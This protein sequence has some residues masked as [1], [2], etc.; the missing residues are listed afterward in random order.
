MNKFSGKLGYSTTSETKPGVFTE[1][2]VE[3]DIVGDII[4]NASR[5]ENNSK[6]NLDIAENTQVSIVRSPE[7]PQN[8]RLIKYVKYWGIA[9]AIQKVKYRYPRLLITLGGEY[10]V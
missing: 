10:N 3:L 2:I 1:T 4:E 8:Y 6:V 9:W 7:I 5:F